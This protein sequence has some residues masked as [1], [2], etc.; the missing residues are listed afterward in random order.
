[1][2]KLNKKTFTI[3]SDTHGKF[4]QITIRKCDYLLICGDMIDRRKPEKMDKFVHWLEQLD[5]KHILIVYGNHEKRVKK[6]FTE[7]L[8]ALSNVHVLQN[9]LCVLDDIQFYGFSFHIGEEEYKKAM[10]S[11]DPTKKCVLLSHKP[12]F[13]IRDLRMKDTKIKSKGY[14]SSG[15][16]ELK[17]ICK[18]IRPDLCCFGH[19]HFSAGKKRIGNTLYINAAIVN[20]FK[21]VTNQPTEVMFNGSSF[22][23]GSWSE[24][25]LCL[26]TLDAK[27]F[28]KKLTL[29]SQQSDSS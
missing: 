12:P 17:D 23:Y 13:G 21:K 16:Y 28:I 10:E 4:E 20:E 8:S 14:K 7:K 27:P 25:T 29:L 15:S 22:H 11:I 5:V 24:T 2:L 19:C 26:Y 3:I 9:S 1:M 18:V 6:E